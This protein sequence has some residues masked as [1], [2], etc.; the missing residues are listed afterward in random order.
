MKR[1]LLLLLLLSQIQEIAAQQQDSIST[2]PLTLEECI[3]YA[4]EN[5]LTI[6]NSSIDE[7]IA[8]ARVKETRGI[9]LPQ[10]DANLSVQHNVK[11]Q[12]FYNRADVLGQFTGATIEDLP[13][14]AIVA[15]SNPFQLKSTGIGTL[16]VSQI[17]FNGSY[18]VGLRAANAYKDLSVKAS[19][20]TREEVIVQV[21]KAYYTALINNERM[22]LFDNNIGRVDSLLRTTRALHENGFAESIDVDRIRVTLNNLKTERENFNN[23]QVLSIELLKFQMNYPMDKDLELEGD[24]NSIAI[25]ESSAAYDAEWDYSNRAD[26]QVLMANRKMQMLNVKNNYAAGLPSLVAQYNYGY[27]TQSPD[28]AGVFRTETPSSSSFNN[29]LGPD[30]WYSYSNFSVSLAIPIFS[31]LQRS[32][33]V[34]QAKLELKKVENNLNSLKSGID[35]EIKQSKTIYDNSLK[36][37]VSQ[38]ENLELAEN[39]ARVTKIKYEEGV[40]SNIEVIDAESALKETQIN[41]YNALY[42]ALVAK[43]DLDKAYGKLNN[44]SSETK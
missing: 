3:Q 19:R 33:K 29:M 16:T 32:Y 21:T 11:L 6:K 24:I 5:S 41:Y 22:T 31:G 42:D 34:Q 15:G 12:R 20:Q 10:V 43:V 9:G 25:P 23:L 14:D 17:L 7:N 35:L 36:T 30:K 13:S 44:L 40:G 18:L 8:K 2:G 1:Y 27:F 37:L 28:L 4:L 39:V 38:R 26:Y